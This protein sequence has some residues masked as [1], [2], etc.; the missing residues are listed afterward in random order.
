MERNIQIRF[1]FFL[2]CI[3]QE[4]FSQVEISFSRFV[5]QLEFSNDNLFEVESQNGG[6]FSFSKGFFRGDGNFS[7]FL[8]L[9]YSFNNGAKLKTLT[10]YIFHNI[11]NEI[12]PENSKI[13]LE[14]NQLI[15]PLEMQLRL[16]QTSFIALFGKLNLHSS[17]KASWVISETKNSTLKGN[18]YNAINDI[19]NLTVS[20]GGGILFDLSNLLTS[21]VQTTFVF[22]K[23]GIQTNASDLTKNKI[24]RYSNNLIYDNNKTSQNTL[25]IALGIQLY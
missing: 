19:T 6:E 24:N 7:L 22:I 17:I 3:F 10:P 16:G 18:S 8:G 14:I 12:A 1:F 9:G 25:Y 5:S 21:T 4:G 15:I 11:S 23:A 2:F 20:Y 13:K